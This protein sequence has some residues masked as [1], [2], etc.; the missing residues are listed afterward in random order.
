MQAVVKTTRNEQGVKPRNEAATTLEQAGA[1]DAFL[2]DFLDLAGPAAPVEFGVAVSSEQADGGVL[3]FGDAIL[4][5]DGDRHDR[6][7]V[8]LII[9]W[10]INSGA[11]T[12][13]V[14][15]RTEEH[16]YRA[17]LPNTFR[18]PTISALH[19]ALGPPEKPL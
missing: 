5:I 9:G 17:C 19:T 2:P 11:E 4:M 16:P 13:C 18:A 10:S 1:T 15:M 14:E 3:V 7:P 6:V 8:E 12:F